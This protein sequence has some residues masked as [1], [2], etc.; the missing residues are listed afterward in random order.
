MN[1]P[2]LKLNPA[3]MKTTDRHVWINII[4]LCKIL[5]MTGDRLI[6]RMNCLS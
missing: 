3:S 1:N 6:Q 2:R 4:F 5:T